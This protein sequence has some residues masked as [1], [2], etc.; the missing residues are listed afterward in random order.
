MKG[1]P[2]KSYLRVFGS[3]RLRD[4]YTEVETMLRYY[5]F[6][7]VLYSQILD[8]SDAHTDLRNKETQISRL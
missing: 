8:L 2:T 6:S 4:T 5:N 1:V 3:I 7:T